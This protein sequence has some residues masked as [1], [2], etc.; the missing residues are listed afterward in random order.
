[1]TTATN[2][3]QAAMQE[4]ESA[5]A[6]LRQLADERARLALAA[7]AGEPGV[8]AKLAAVEAQIADARLRLDRAAAAAGAVEAERERQ[9]QAEAARQLL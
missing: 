7:L 1:M 6:L 3:E 8:G 4:R 5:S 2:I 9:R